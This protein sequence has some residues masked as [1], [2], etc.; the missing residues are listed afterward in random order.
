MKHYKSNFKGWQLG[1]TFL[2]FMTHL[3]P[4]FSQENELPDGSINVSLQFSSNS[5]F[6]G[7]DTFLNKAVQEKKSYGSNTGAW[8]AI[9]SITYNAPVEGLYFNWV[10]SFALEARGDV[11]IDQRFESGASGDQTTFA[12][13][14]A[15]A[16]LSGESLSAAD[17][18]GRQALSN[19]PSLSGQVNQWPAVPYTDLAVYE[20]HDDPNGLKRLDEMDFTLGYERET[21]VGT[22]G[23]GI[24]HQA[25]SDT[26]GKG[27]PF[28]DGGATYLLTE[29]FATYA[30][31]MLPEVSLYLGSD[32]IRSNQYYRLAYSK[33]FEITEAFYIGIDTGP[34]YAVNEKFQ[35]WNDITSTLEFGYSGFN[36]T[37]NAACRPDSRFYDPDPF[38][39]DLIAYDGG[40]T[41]EDGLVEDPSRFKNG[42]Y[43][44]V[45]NAIITENVRSITGNPNYTYI[46]RQ[47]IPRWLYWVNFGYSTTL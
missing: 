31:P 4:V 10:G 47:K 45:L 23:F 34:G 32:V 37:F 6:R 44:D 25:L 18:A 33:E 22:L 8:L 2:L 46:P 19:H 36:I 1:C 13:A 40:S 42:F 21:K 26:S 14:F 24:L 5:I 29:V 17:A 41:K 20:L 15:A 43:T 38:T 30:L 11:D 39:T 7:A 27:N 28:T 16:L 12:D 3:A 35:G 9:P